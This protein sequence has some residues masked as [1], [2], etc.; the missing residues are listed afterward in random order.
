MAC[1]N[2]PP[3][4]WNFKPQ[5]SN[6]LLI[7][8]T[9]PWF[10]PAYKAG[11]PVQS[12]A[13]TTLEGIETGKWIDYNADSKVWYA[14]PGNVSDELVQQVGKINPDALF[15]VGIFSWHFNMV[16]LLFTKVAKKILSVRGMLHPGALGQKKI[17]KRLYLAAFKIR[18]MHKKIVFHATDNAEAEFIRSEFG[19]DVNVHVASNFPRNIGWKQPIPKQAGRLEMISIGLISPMK[20][21]LLVLGALQH[22]D[23]DINY[24]IY[25]PIK[26]MEYWQQ[27]L[28]LVKTLPSN[29]KVEYHGEIPP[30]G[31]P[32][33]L[34][35]SHV[36]ILPS[37]SENFG[38]AIYEALSSGRPVITS[39][40]TPWND[41]QPA[42]AGINCEA[43]LPG[44]KKAIVFF[45]AMNDVEYDVWNKGAA[46]YALKALNKADIKLQ[47]NEMFSV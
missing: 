18:G 46:E 8:I 4:T 22:S 27:C 39:N 37:K 28:Q 38:H 25:G 35:A 6:P 20:N 45:A 44:I 36:F 10:S 42:S 32:A 21:I 34:H 19:E 40:T 11:G 29:I 9:I 31:I 13:N 12:I 23:D 17:K 47:Y 16:P 43:N 1:S 33:L 3:L 14:T 2:F 24:K 7:F 41:L 15:I 26:D 30:A 5:T